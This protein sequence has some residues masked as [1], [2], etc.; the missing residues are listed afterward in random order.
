MLLISY[1]L[2]TTPS[3]YFRFRVVVME[4]AIVTYHGSVGESSALA[5]TTTQ[6]CACFERNLA[7]IVVPE[8]PYIPL[9]TSHLEIWLTVSFGR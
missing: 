1:L 8:Y 9:V 4:L 2:C 3:R 7:G 6:R 5:L